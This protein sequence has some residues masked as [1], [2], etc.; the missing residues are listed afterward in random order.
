MAADEFHVEFRPKTGNGGPFT[1]TNIFPFA[2]LGIEKACFSVSNVGISPSNCFKYAAMN[3]DASETEPANIFESIS[4]VFSDQVAELPVGFV[5]WFQIGLYY[6]LTAF[7]PSR[8]HGSYEVLTVTQETFD[9]I[10]RILVG[11][12]IGDLCLVLKPLGVA[13]GKEHVGIHPETPLSLSA[14]ES[15]CY[16]VP[17]SDKQS[18]ALQD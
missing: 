14:K 15:F 3:E 6:H 10:K 8:V 12:Q 17:A 13:E 7:G 9:C 11:A 1:E 2:A 4:L 5:P 18:L 16:D